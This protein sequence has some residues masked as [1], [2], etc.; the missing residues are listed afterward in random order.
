MTHLF[1]S[2]QFI[3][4]LHQACRKW[5]FLHALKIHAGKRLPDEIDQN[6]TPFDNAQT[7]VTQSSKVGS[8]VAIPFTTIGYIM[9]T[10][11]NRYAGAGMLAT[12][13]LLALLTGCDSTDS[14][15]LTPPS[16]SIGNKIDDSVITA[17]VRSALLSNEEVKSLDIKVATR[18]G[19]VMLSGFTVNQKQ[20]DLSIAVA[21]SVEGVTNVDNQLALKEGHQSIGNRIDDSV[22]T[23]RVK[24]AILADPAMKS[25][26]VGVTTRK[27][28]VMLS[29]FVDNSVLQGQAIDLA[30]DVD[31]VTSVVDHMSIKK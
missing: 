29:G 5:L 11:S 30:R 27:G 4:H 26:D 28:E 23:A 16:T 8:L 3:S 17:K 31:G 9:T 13:L 19:E 25:M 24:A 14:T 6:S 22:I 10:I 2:L 18:K 7:G 20:I 15:G 21:K 12:C 1:G